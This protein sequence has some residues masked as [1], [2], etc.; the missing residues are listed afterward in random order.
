MQKRG[1]RICEY[2]GEKEE[3]GYSIGCEV[4]EEFSLIEISFSASEDSSDYLVT[5]GCKEK[6]GGTEVIGEFL[7]I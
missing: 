7:E 3:T 2:E 4:V 1:R 6:D 5:E